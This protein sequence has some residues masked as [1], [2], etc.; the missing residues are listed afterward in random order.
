M[1]RPSSKPIS[2]RQLAKIARVDVSTVS[3]CLNHDPRVSDERSKK[4]RELAERMGYRPKPLRGKSTKTIGLMIHGYEEGPS[5]QF[6]G[7]IFWHIE[8]LLAESGYHLSVALISPDD[9]KPKVPT[10]ILENRVDGALL[11]GHFPVQLVKEM[12]EYEVPMVAINDAVQ[13][14]HI[15]C[16]RSDP[17]EAIRE[18]VLR[19]CA[20]GHKHLALALSNVD[21]PTHRARLDSFLEALSFAGIK[22]TKH[23]VIECQKV[24]LLGGREVAQHII[25]SKH[26][27]TALICENDWMAIGAIHEFANKG[28]SVPKEMSVVGHDDVPICREFTPHLTTIQRSEE[29]LVRSAIHL[30]L[31]RPGQTPF[32]AGEIFIPG[33]PFWRE[34]TGPVNS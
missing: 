25:K 17:T 4:I 3:R 32:N 33:K 34:S 15:P 5:S 11:A 22:P 18:I 10:M 6:L 8:R 19:L 16:V 21:Y 14:I 9:R 27:T 2:L 20:W 31:N 23:C 28:I 24:D 13:R 29:E 1:T 7:R 12:K 30:L 26:P